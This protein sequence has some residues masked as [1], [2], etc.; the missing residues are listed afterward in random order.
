MIGDLSATAAVVIG[1]S[2][3]E[4]A[5]V[6]A[7]AADAVVVG[8]AV[9]DVDFESLPHADS[10]SAPVSTAAMHNLRF[11]LTFKSRSPS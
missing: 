8:A 2:L 7:V 9:V 6:V 11:L 4:V 1:A 5:A 10:T 3:D